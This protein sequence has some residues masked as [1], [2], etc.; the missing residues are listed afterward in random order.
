MDKVTADFAVIFLTEDNHEYELMFM[1]KVLL[2]TRY[3]SSLM[4][5]AIDYCI[6]V[7]KYI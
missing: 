5:T 1:T 3:Y 2:F 7:H 6:S 4:S